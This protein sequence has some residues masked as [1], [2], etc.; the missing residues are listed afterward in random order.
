VSEI[1]ILATGS[2][3]AGVSDGLPSLKALADESTGAAVRR[4]GRF[5]QLALVGAGRC[6]GERTLPP[7]TAT[8]VTSVRGDLEVTIEGLAEVCERGRSPAP[9]TFINT[10]GNSACFHVAK[11]FGLRGRSQ[12][13]TSRHG[14]L[15]AALRLAAFDIAEDGVTTALVG[16]IDAATLPLSAHRERIE[17]KADTAIGEASHWLLL[18]SAPSDERALG[19]LRRVQRLRDHSALLEVLAQLRGAFRDVALAIGP[20]LDP[21]ALD[22]V[23][24]TVGICR[25]LAYRDGLPW[26]DSQLGHAL[27]RFLTSPEAQTLVHVDGDPSG[28]RSLI[29]IDASP[30]GEASS[31]PP[32]R[33]RRIA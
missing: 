7:D 21:I 6:V 28:R 33:D 8:Y 15:E 10:V 23:R 31:T 30:R 11:C 12:F 29:V 32:P 14:A 16:S 3:V 2:Y 26:Y 9:F 19:V 20:H 5:V 18:S 17:V 25:E 13:V 27:H 1:R 24:A 22:S 4:I